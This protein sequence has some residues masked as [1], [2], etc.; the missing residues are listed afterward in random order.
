M[1]HMARIRVDLPTMYK[2]LKEHRLPRSLSD[3]G[4][5]V[6][7]YLQDVFNGQ[8]PTPFRVLEGDGRQIDI[9]AYTDVELSVASPEVSVAM[10]SLP[11][12]WPT[13]KRMAFEVTA[14]PVVRMASSGPTHKKGAEVDVFLRECWR[15]GAGKDV[16]RSAVYGEW[17]REKLIKQGAEIE[18]SQV[19]SYKRV[20]L[21]RKTQGERRKNH[22]I[23]KPS[24]DFGGVLRVVDSEK[25]SSLLSRGV[26]RHR[27]FGFGM[28]LL[29]RA[30]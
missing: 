4:Y 21:L 20:K 9:L 16:V 25:F 11:T 8:A 5:R 12:M 17:L 29:K 6:H 22:E 15:Q 28:L 26:G 10:K 1:T 2:R 30:S 27:S 23:D 19:L 13:G 24:V 7:A 3:D 14:C 18:S